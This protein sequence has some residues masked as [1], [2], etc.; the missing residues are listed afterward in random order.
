MGTLAL[1]TS[2]EDI[3][4]I[5]IKVND[6]DKNPIFE[7]YLHVDNVNQETQIMINT[8]YTDLVKNAIMTAY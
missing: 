1:V 3:K 4:N 2:Y 5:S 8:D 6:T 7:L